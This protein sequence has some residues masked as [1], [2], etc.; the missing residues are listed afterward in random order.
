MATEDTYVPPPVCG[1]QLRL[2]IEGEPVTG[3]E[4]V[5]DLWA[6]CERLLGRV[7]QDNEEGHLTHIKFNWLKE[8]F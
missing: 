6:T 8:N 3:L 5:P 7:P 1:V 2:S 4:K